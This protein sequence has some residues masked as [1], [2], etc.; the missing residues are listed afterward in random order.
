M[1][2]LVIV[3]TIYS[4]LLSYHQLTLHRRIQELELVPVFELSGIGEY[5]YGELLPFSS[6]QSPSSCTC[7]P[8]GGCTNCPIINN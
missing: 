5:E 3:L 7:G 4:L 2:L 8:N 1:E 6:I